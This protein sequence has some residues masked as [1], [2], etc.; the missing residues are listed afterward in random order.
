MYL[1]IT[2]CDAWP[3]LIIERAEAISTVFPVFRIQSPTAK[4]HLSQGHHDAPDPRPVPLRLLPGDQPNPEEERRELLRVP[5]PT[6]SPTS[7]PTSWAPDERTRPHGYLR[8]P[9]VL[10]SPP[11]TR[12]PRAPWAGIRLSA[13]TRRGRPKLHDHRP[14]S[15]LMRPFVTLCGPG[16][17]AAVTSRPQPEHNP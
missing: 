8:G 10:T 16:R 17:T 11:L 6:A 15:T 2:C 14:I 12:G 4:L 5:P 7:P 1:S 9:Q 13:H 3:G